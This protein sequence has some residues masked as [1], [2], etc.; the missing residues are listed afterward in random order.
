MR[1]SA[2]LPVT[3][4]VVVPVWVP[5]PLPAIRVTVCAPGVLKTYGRLGLEFARLFGLPGLPRG[6]PGNV[7]RGDLR[8]AA[9]IRAFLGRPAFIILERPVRGVYA[10]LPPLLTAVHSAR[11]RGCAVLWTVTDPKI[12]NHPGTRATTRARMF[13]SQLQAVETES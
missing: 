12:W 1:L 4:I 11:K 7:R 13:G 2:A 9:C 5:A 6:R 3:V 8:R 10:L